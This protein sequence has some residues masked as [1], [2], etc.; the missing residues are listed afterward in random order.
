MRRWPE[1]GLRT[2]NCRVTL[3]PGSIFSI[4]MAGRSIPCSSRRTETFVAGDPLKFCTV[5]SIGSGTPA[6][7]VPP[8]GR[9]DEIARFGRAAST[10]SINCGWT[11]AELNFSSSFLIAAACVQ[12]LV[13]KSETMKTVWFTSAPSPMICA[14]AFSASAGPTAVCET[15]QGGERFVELLGELA[16]FDIFAGQVGLRAARGARGLRKA[17]ERELLPRRLLGS[18]LA[19]AGDQLLG[20]VEGGGVGP[21]VGHRKAVV[22]QHDVVQLLAAEQ[23]AELVLDDRLRDH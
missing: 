9:S 23:T 22:Q 1:V 19:E 8:A 11:P 13:R 20:F 5:T 21:M 12:S 17:Q 2:S 15:A 16:A 10:Q 3:R 6:A 7:R 4:S 18:L 14:A